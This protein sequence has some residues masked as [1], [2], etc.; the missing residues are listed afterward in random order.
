MDQEHADKRSQRNRSPAVYWRL[1]TTS[2]YLIYVILVFSPWAF[3]TTEDWAIK[4]VNTL[5][6]LLGALLVAKWI[7]RLVI[8]FH[9]ARWDGP[10]ALRGVHPAAHLIPLAAFTV[11]M[12]GYTAL[13]AWNARADFFFE[14]QRFQYF[15]YKSWLPTS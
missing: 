12:L 13:A 10:A 1:D 2:E 4:T 8:G 15:D 5:N 6:Y 14:E 3:G 7:T 9:P 11:I